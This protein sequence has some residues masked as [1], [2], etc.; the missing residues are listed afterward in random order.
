MLLPLFC[1][2]LG[3]GA[4]YPLLDFY[5]LLL[6]L[7]GSKDFPG[8]DF[9]KTSDRVVEIFGFIILGHLGH[10]FLGQANIPGNMFIRGAAGD[11][12]GSEFAI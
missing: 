12:L 2:S 3:R 1:L 8:V 10:P 4:K 11:H 9:G 6:L 7:F 5:S